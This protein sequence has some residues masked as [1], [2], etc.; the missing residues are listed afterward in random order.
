MSSI[1]HI[2]LTTGASR[3]S[4]RREVADA[5]VERLRKDIAGGR[6]LMGTPWRAMI[7]PAPEGAY[8]IDL[9]HNGRRM[10]A[11]WL[12]R[13]AGLSNELW[14]VISEAG[15]SLPGTRLHQPRSTPWLAAALVPEADLMRDPMALAPILKEAGDLERCVAWA[16]LE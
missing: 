6:A 11:C 3:I 9:L 5:V 4:H 10:V 14:R 1:E 7:H 13:E 2:T 16:L 8:V 15:L 12:C